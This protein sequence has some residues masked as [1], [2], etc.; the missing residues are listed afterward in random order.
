VKLRDRGLEKADGRLSSF[1]QSLDPPI[2]PI[3][4][5]NDSP[6]PQPG[7]PMPP[8]PRP[9][10][11]DRLPKRV[12]RT[13]GDYGSGHLKVDNLLRD[14]DR[15]DYYALLRK[16]G[17]TVRAA[18]LWLRERGYKVGRGA[19]KHHKRKFGQKLD[20]IRNSAEMSLVCADLVRQVGTARMSDA[21]VLR[22]ETL[23]TEALF[24]LREGQDLDG[25]RWTTMGRAL[26]HAVTNRAKVEALR[27]AA[28][29]AEAASRSRRAGSRRTDGAA[30]SDKVRR[31]LGMPLPGEPIPGLPAPPAEEARSNPP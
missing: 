20:T 31:I 27:A 18:W 12:E 3:P 7:S 15:N 23:L 30:L 17:T 8:S 29:E 16:P 2:N 5:P 1:S 14:E 24:D 28:A 13:P 11:A 6:I 25:D 9:S 10:P 22:F 21:A 26:N 4:I 19:V